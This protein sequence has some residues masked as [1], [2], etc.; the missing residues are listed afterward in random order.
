MLVRDGGRY[1]I[2]VDDP[3][4]DAVIAALATPG[5]TCELRIPKDRL[6]PVRDPGDGSGV[7]P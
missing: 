2:T 1:A 3:N 6:R 4:T 7:K 5:G